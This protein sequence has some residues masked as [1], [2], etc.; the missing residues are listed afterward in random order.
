[1]T[2][3]TDLRID[4]PHDQIVDFCKRWKVQELALF[5]SVL[6]DDF[7]PES[8]VDMLV[9]FQEGY[10]YTIT[11]L[12]DM[13]EELEQLFGRKVDLI[14]KRA[15]EDSPNYIRRRAILNS[16]RVIYAG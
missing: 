3:P 14:T 7:T 10:R 2:S 12:L 8:D 1:M 9:S 15:I 13:Q 11:D 6:R 16:A 4:V 5:G